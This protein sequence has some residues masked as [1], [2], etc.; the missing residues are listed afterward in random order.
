MGCGWCTG[1]SQ[2]A[3][4]QP[5]PSSDTCSWATWHLPCS[6]ASAGF[7]CRSFCSWERGLYGLPECIQWSPSPPSDFP[8]RLTV[9][10]LLVIT[11]EAP[12]SFIF[13][14]LRLQGHLFQFSEDW[15]GCCAPLFRGMAPCWRLHQAPSI[16]GSRVHRCIWM[17]L[18]A[19]TGSPSG[20]LA[21]PWATAG[22]SPSGWPPQP[23]AWLRC[24]WC[25]VA[26]QAEVPPWCCLYLAPLV[27]HLLSLQQ[28]SLLVP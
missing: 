6:P 18:P 24:V 1:G 28:L 16:P 21:C 25:G 17:H 23:P 26:T 20:W 19:P 2:P 27:F 5:P 15:R 13:P 7:P 9:F 4:P 11:P 14:S 3:A 8:H 10:P 22:P 12:C